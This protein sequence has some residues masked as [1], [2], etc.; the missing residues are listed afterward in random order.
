MSPRDSLLGADVAEH[1]Q[2]LLLFSAH[3]FFLSSGAV[4]TREFRDTGLI[5]K[6]LDNTV[7]SAQKGADSYAIQQTNRPL[8]SSI[9]DAF[10]R[11]TC[12]GG[13]SSPLREGSQFE[14]WEFLSHQ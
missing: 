1:V 7:S 3:A 2:L 9:S 12:T 10:L 13:G 6:G 5:A 11:P 4:E 14:E 8:A